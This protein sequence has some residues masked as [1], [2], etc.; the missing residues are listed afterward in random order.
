MNVTMGC[1]DIR[2]RNKVPW[3]MVTRFQNM[4]VDVDFAVRVVTDGI[5]SYVHPWHIGGRFVLE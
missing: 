1:L 3:Y 5:V 4:S 2:I